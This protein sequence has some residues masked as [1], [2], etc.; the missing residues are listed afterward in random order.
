ME[1]FIV[2][3]LIFNVP[4]FELTE[5]DLYILLVSLSPSLKYDICNSVH[6]LFLYTASQQLLASQV[7]THSNYCSHENCK[8]LH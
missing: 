8:N 7:F 2:K 6:L 5:L 3:R 1:L 4:R